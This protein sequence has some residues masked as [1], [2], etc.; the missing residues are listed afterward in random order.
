MHFSRVGKFFAVS[1]VTGPRHNLLQL[2]LS[3]SAEDKPVLE[4]LPAIGN[5]THATLDPDKLL[6]AV[7]EGVT[8]AN[9]EFGTTFS[10]AHIRY[11]ANDTSPEIVYGF[12]ALS[13][14]RHLVS[15]GTFVEA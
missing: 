12:L 1:R 3:E 10:A 13:I 11:V 7:I 9:N 6:A 2:C 15:G 14:V 8:T 4:C 5:C